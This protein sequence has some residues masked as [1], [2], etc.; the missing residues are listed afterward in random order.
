MSLRGRSSSTFYTHRT[1]TSTMFVKKSLKMPSVSKNEVL[2]ASFWNSLFWS[3]NVPQG[4]I[5]FDFLHTQDTN[6]NNVRKKSLK[7]P[8]VLKN[9]VLVASFWNCFCILI[10]IIPKSNK[11]HH[12]VQYFVNNI[13]SNTAWNNIY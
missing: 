8:S 13:C 1:Q 11:C 12:K 2:V 6:I 10:S 3:T 4:K 7:M 9:E 5:I